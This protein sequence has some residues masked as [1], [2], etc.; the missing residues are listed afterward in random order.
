MLNDYITGARRS[1]VTALAP[2]IRTIPHGWWKDT[3]QDNPNKV[4]VVCH[5]CAEG[6]VI[7]NGKTCTCPKCNGDYLHYIDR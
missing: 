7:R 6:E 4:R 3:V 1:V 2:T 5:W